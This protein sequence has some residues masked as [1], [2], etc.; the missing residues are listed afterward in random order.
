MAAVAR[1][2]TFGPPTRFFDEKERRTLGVEGVWGIWILSEVT[3][4][5]DCWR[6]RVPREMRIKDIIAHLF[7]YHVIARKNWTI[8]QLVK[9]VKTVEPD[10]DIHLSA[11]PATRQSETIDRWTVSEQLEEYSAQEEIEDWQAVRRAFAAK[12]DAGRRRTRIDR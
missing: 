5:C 4:P 11:Q 3:R 2:C 12:S 6:F 8:D 7:D 9:W 10:D 1:G